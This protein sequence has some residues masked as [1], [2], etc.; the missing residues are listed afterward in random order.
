[1]LAVTVYEIVNKIG[2][3]RAHGS[4]QAIVLLFFFKNISSKSTSWIS[5][6]QFIDSENL[7]LYS[8]FLSV[9]QDGFHDYTW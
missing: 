4:V 6:E 9:D 7:N 2:E 1:M 3:E 5:S 8:W